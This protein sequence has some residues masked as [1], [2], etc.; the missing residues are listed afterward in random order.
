Q[1]A[2]EQSQWQA[3]SYGKVYKESDESCITRRKSDNLKLNK[4]NTQLGEIT[5]Y[6]NQGEHKQLTFLIKQLAF[7]CKDIKSMHDLSVI[8]LYMQISS[9]LIQY[10]NKY[11]LSERLAPRIGLYPLYY[12]HNFENWREAFGYL[13]KLVNIMFELNY[14][15]LQDKN[16]RL[17]THIKE[18]IHAHLQENLNLSALSDVVNYNSTYVSRIFKQTTGMNLSDYVTACRINKAK[19]LLHNSSTSIHSISEKVGFDTC[20]YFCMVFRKEVGITPSEYRKQK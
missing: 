13:E 11:E 1:F 10:I 5:A 14:G 6:L 18:Y 4:W 2:L 19:E 17:V 20:Q 12:I 9:M 15:G 7:F 16:Q 8:G 3:C